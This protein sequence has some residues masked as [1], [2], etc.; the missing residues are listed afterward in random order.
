MDC[1]AP[2]TRGGPLRAAIENP[3]MAGVGGALAYR[4]GVGLDRIVNE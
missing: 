4:V 3:L 2:A 1:W